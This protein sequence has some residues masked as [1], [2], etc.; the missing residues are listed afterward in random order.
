MRPAAITLATPSG[1]GRQAS[2]PRP[3]GGRWRGTSSPAS[4]IR[5]PDPSAGSGAAGGPTHRRRARPPRASAGLAAFALADGSRLAFVAEAER[6][7]V[8]NR[9]VVRYPYRQPFGR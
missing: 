7:R 2:A 3:T 9:L 4:T 6:S 5:R 1:A 8:E